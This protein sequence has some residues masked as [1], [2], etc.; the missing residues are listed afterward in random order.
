MTQFTRSGGPLRETLRDAELHG[1][2]LNGSDYPLPGIDPLI[3]TGLLVEQGYLSAEERVGLNALFDYSPLA[4]DF[5]VKRCLRAPTPAGA[6]DPA[7][8][9][10]PA[11]VFETLRAFPRLA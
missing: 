8:R 2:L 10:L 11:S 5:A 3:R 1:R 7:G 9:Q 6:H 4:F